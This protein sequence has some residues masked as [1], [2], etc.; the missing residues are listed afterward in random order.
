MALL[1]GQMA[2][3]APEECG[4]GDHHYLCLFNRTNV[5]SYTLTTPKRWLVAP[6]VAV[7]ELPMGRGVRDFYRA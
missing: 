3:H 7:D 6:R 1:A 4:L 5:H 2:R